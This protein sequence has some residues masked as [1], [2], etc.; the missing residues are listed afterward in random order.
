MLGKAGKKMRKITSI[1][2]L[3]LVL[4][5][6]VN[7]CFA[8]TSATQTVQDAKPTMKDVDPNTELGKSIQKLIDAGVVNGIPEEDGTFTY[9]AQN[10]ITRAEFCKMINTTFGYNVAAD[11]IFSDVSPEKWYYVHVLY[12]IEKEYIK[13]KGD[14]TFGGEDNITREQVCVI[15]DRIVGKKPD[16]KPALTDEVSSWAKDAVENI[17]GLGYMSLE[18]GG[19][20]RATDNMTRGELAFALDDFVKVIPKPEGDNTQGGEGSEN[21]SGNESGNGN[22]SDNGSNSNSN[23]DSG[24]KE[25]IGSDNDSPNPGDNKDP[26][27]EAVY[28]INYMVDGGYF[29]GVTP[30]Y[31]YKSSDDSY[32]LPAPSKTGHKFMGWFRTA[33]AD[34]LTDE[35]VVSIE[36][37]SSGN[38]TFYAKWAKEYK[39][40]YVLHPAEYENQNDETILGRLDEAPKA[41]YIEYDEEYVLPIPYRYDGNEFLGWYI[42]QEFEGESGAIIYSPEYLMETIPQGT[43]GNITLHA[44]WQSM[45]DYSDDTYW[46]IDDA[47]TEIVEMKEDGLLELSEESGML[48]FFEDALPEVLAWQDQGILVTKTLVRGVYESDANTLRQSY[49]ELDITERET[50]RNELLGMR[51]STTLANIFGLNT[52]FGTEE[53]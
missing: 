24:S 36:K 29:G 21:G 3:V 16:T 13:G 14:G 39:I 7:V 19:K 25:D 31:S 5:M 34:M 40:T 8:D 42:P 30:K 23:S 22:T 35:K 50:I 48:A 1:L 10:E 43:T 4:V 9:R 17:I 46:Y 51:N 28:S 32:V 47:I 41:S 15:L 20:F 33:D 2:A 53:D 27:P 11:N 49:L 38:K 37:G 45:L 52:L 44:V 6:S 12:A 26:Q 18:E